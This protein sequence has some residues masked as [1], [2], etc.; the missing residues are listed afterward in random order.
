MYPILDPVWGGGRSSGMH[1][2]RVGLPLP[3]S[4]TSN[5]DGGEV[6]EQQGRM[7][8]LLLSGSNYDPNPHHARLLLLAGVSMPLPWTGSSWL[9]PATAMLLVEQQL[10]RVG[11]ALQWLHEWLLQPATSNSQWSA[12]G[13]S[14]FRLPSHLCVIHDAAAGQHHHVECQ[15]NGAH[16]GRCG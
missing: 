12:E 4:T 2:G 7:E 16:R 13:P 15:H 10:E 8:H 5:P 11:R 9:Q 6:V 14:G 3:L 1:L